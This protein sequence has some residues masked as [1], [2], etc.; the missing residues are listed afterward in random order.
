MG[1]LQD[2]LTE[3]GNNGVRVP[4]VYDPVSKAPSVTLMF[5]VVTFWIAVASLVGLHFKPTWLVPCITAICWWALATILYMIRKITKAKF[6]VQNKSF[7][8]ENDEPTK[9]DSAQS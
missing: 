7:S 2:K 8:V 3:W 9:S 6:D 5:A 1:K 4:L